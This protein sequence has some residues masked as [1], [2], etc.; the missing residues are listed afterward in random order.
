[1]NDSGPIKQTV[2]LRDHF[3]MAALKGL[4]AGPLNLSA[5]S[6]C[7]MAYEYADAM[8]KKRAIAPM[9]SRYGSKKK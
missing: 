8:L 3:A 7:E 2:S 6:A 9:S 4:I 1:M 5:A